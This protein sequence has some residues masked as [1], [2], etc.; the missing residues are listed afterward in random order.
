MKIK[1]IILLC[2][3]FI[4]QMCTVVK[5]IHKIY[6]LEQYGIR[7]LDINFVTGTEGVFEVKYNCTDTIISFK[8]DFKYKQISKNKIMVIGTKKLDQEIFFYLPPKVCKICSISNSYLYKIPL[9]TEEEILINHNSL[10]WQKIQN[11]KIVSAFTF[12]AE[13][14]NIITLS[15]AR[16][17]NPFLKKQPYH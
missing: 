8:Q 13:W 7:K 15:K 12:F 14:V 17:C 10:F 6:S 2:S 5:P 11:K 1:N 3:F 16:I 9:I 4:F